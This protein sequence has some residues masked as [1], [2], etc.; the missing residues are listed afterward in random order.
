MIVL[1]LVALAWATLGVVNLTR[2]HPGVGVLYLVVGVL[3]G[4]A[5]MLIKPGRRSR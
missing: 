2:G 5:A 4:T 3:T 1:A